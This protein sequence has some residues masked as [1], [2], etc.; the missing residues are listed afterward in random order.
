LEE[1]T[2]IDAFE[3]GR[4]MKHEEIYGDHVEAQR[5]VHEEA[6]RRAVARNTA[7]EAATP[8]SGMLP[9]TMDMNAYSAAERADALAAS[10]PLNW[11]GGNPVISPVHIPAEEFTGL[12][13]TPSVRGHGELFGV[14]A[15]AGRGE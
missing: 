11:G 5:A 13:S 3:G 7:D 6:H 4:E 10:G 1:T 12:T 2:F 15:V 8:V 9:P 14:S